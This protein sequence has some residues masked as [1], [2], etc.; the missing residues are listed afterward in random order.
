MSS[1]YTRCPVSRL[2]HLPDC[3]TSVITWKNFQP[4]SQ[5]R[6]SGIPSGLALL[7]CN[8][9]VDFCCAY[10]RDRDLCK[11]SQPGS[12]YQALSFIASFYALPALTS[13]IVQSRPN[14]HTQNFSPPNFSILNE[15]P[16]SKFSPYKYYQK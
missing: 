13:P 6:N 3:Q 14:P 12:C 5:H 15:L 7:S 9:K 16:I 11:A 1:V 8:S 10:L 4:G 2:V